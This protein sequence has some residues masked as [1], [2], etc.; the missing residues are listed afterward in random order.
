MIPVSRTFFDDRDFAAVVEPLRKGWVVQ[1]E[2]VRQF[3]SLFST[4][5]AQPFSIA[6]SSCTTA[7]HLALTA[8]GIGAGDEVLVPAF[9]WIATASSV[10]QAG[11]VPVFVDIDL[12]TFTIDPALIEA[13]ITPRTRAIMPVHQFGFAADMPRI[14]A[15]A[16]RHDL[17][18][19]EDAAC[20][21]GTTL[22]GTHVGGFGDAGCFS[23]HPRK[24]ITTGEGWHGHHGQRRH[25]CALPFVARPRRRA[26]KRAPRRRSCSPDF[27]LAGFNY[28]LTDIQ[29]ALGCSQMAKAAEILDSRRH[30][31]ALYDVLLADCDWLQLPARRDGVGHSYQS[32]VCLFAPEAPTAASRSALHAPAQ[33]DHD[34]AGTAGHQHTPGHAL[35]ATHI[36]LRHA[37]RARRGHLSAVT[38]GRVALHR[39]AA[40]RGHARRG[41]PRGGGRPS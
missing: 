37:L 4:F 10:V 9:T 36:L 14:M 15:I 31:A 20:G 16:R 23:F 5:T 17:R 6:T 21:F 26:R 27:P 2:Y 33:R 32:Y 13:A 29:G 25:R 1:G 38:A 22:D 28:R 35:G 3:E 34:R 30:I 39:T 8:L 12:A 24:A 41:G 18:V 40:V 19:I 7:L 11:A